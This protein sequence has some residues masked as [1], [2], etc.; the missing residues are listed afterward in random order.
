MRPKYAA[1]I[2]GVRLH[3]GQAGALMP[4]SITHTHTHKHTNTHTHAR[5]HA[6]TCT[7]IHARMVVR[8][9]GADSALRLLLRDIDV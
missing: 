4:Y 8:S 1:S 5:M 3:F 6:N 9:T 2:S 7:H